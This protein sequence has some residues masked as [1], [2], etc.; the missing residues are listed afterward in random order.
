MLPSYSD[1]EKIVRGNSAFC[2]KEDVIFGVPVSQYSYRFASYSDFNKPLASSSVSALELRGISFVADNEKN[3]HSR[4]RFLMLHKFFN[5]NQTEGYM[6]RDLC[7]NRIVSAQ[8]K[9]DGSMVRFLKINGNV[10]AKTNFAFD[11][12]Q[13]EAAEEIYR[14]NINIKDIVDYTLSRGVAAMFEFLSPDNR[15][16]VRYPEQKLVL[17]QM[18]R[19]TDGSYFS[20]YA[21]RQTANEFCVDCASF[22]PNNITLDDYVEMAKCTENKEGWVLTFDGGKK[23]KLKTRWYLSLHRAISDSNSIR[24]IVMSAI[25]G[26]SDDLA[27]SLEEYDMVTRDRIERISR[28]VSA[29]QRRISDKIL[30]IVR[31]DFSE[32]RRKEFA[33]A[34]KADKH[35]YMMMLLTK[36]PT[37]ERASEL[38][39]EHL[40]MLA[41]SDE[42]ANML[43]ESINV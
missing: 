19:E 33:I 37:E 36:C 15:I 26:T 7:K 31:R 13:S 41:K 43:L 39:A 24:Q 25:E 22:M 38:A 8:E 32:S 14:K 4:K 30:G 1:C 20:E 5:I 16:V 34:N 18:R 10:K 11:S 29:E 40:K 17:L 28:A 27:S 42:K 12:W 21:V 35:F 9:V 3:L 2:K 23:V 6:L